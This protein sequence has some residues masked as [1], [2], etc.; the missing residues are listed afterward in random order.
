MKTW[1]QNSIKV[2]G[3]LLIFSAPLFMNNSWRKIAKPTFKER[4]MEEIE[5]GRKIAVFVNL[6]S[7]T[8]E[9]EAV[10]EEDLCKIGTS[11]P[12]SGGALKFN[13]KFGEPIPTGY[14]KMNE[15]ATEQLNSWVDAFESTAVQDWWKSDYKVIV[16]IIPQVSYK[17]D[18]NVD[19]MTTSLTTTTLMYVREV[20]DGKKAL[21]SIVNGRVLGNQSTNKVKHDDRV[22]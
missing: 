16:E 17:T 21:G 3:L 12:T 10:L 11:I 5:A 4:V 13:G 6:G 2:T 22:N 9:H 18:K 8:F 1:S 20:V 14:Q 15:I 7:L 19:P